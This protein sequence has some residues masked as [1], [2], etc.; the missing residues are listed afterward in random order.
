M[1]I[2]KYFELNDENTIYQKLL[3]SAKAMV[4]RIFITVNAHIYEE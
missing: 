1:E 2:T 3:D 4:K